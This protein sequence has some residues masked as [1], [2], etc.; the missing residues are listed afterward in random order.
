MDELS[1]EESG[2]SASKY[3]KK[4][5]GAAT[6]YIYDI[7]SSVDKAVSFIGPVKRDI[8]PLKTDN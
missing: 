1:E 3:R 8:C 6:Q 7:Y 2:P 5:Q 4:L